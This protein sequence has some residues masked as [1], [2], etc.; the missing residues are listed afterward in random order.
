MNA[1]AGTQQAPSRS[2]CGAT[3]VSNLSNS[4]PCVTRRWLSAAMPL[5]SLGRRRSPA[6]GSGYLAARSSRSKGRRSSR[7]EEIIAEMRCCG[8]RPHC[9]RA[10]GLIVV[11][12]RAG[13]R[14]QEALGLTELDL[15]PRRG[16]GLVRR[17]KGGHRREVG[18]DDRGFEQLEAWLKVRQATRPARCSA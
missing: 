9:L 3:C 10:G 6:A 4:Q 18:M 8:E 15:D 16:S 13:L 2:P 12:C 7:T 11:L 1:R 5:D 17:R 14:I